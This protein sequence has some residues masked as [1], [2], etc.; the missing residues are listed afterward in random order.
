LGTLPDLRGRQGPTIRYCG[1]A[2]QH[3]APENMLAAR[4]HVINILL[5][6]ILDV[7]AELSY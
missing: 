6:Q 3:P 7:L 5:Q 2:I 4:G 1:G